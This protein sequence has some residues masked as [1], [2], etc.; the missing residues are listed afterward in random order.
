VVG[1]HLDLAQ[2]H[3]HNQPNLKRLSVRHPHLNLKYVGV[4]LRKWYPGRS[5]IEETISTLWLE[6]SFSVLK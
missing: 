1:C 3:P 6:H 4:E 5:L 2:L